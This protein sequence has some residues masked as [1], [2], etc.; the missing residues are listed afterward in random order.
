MSLVKKTAKDGHYTII[1]PSWNKELKDGESYTF[2]CVLGAG[3]EISMTNV[4]VR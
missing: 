2:G 4:R 1:N 3:D